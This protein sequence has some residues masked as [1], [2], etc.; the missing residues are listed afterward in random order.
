MHAVL[1][2]TLRL[3][4]PVPQNIRE[5]RS[6]PVLFPQSD[7][8]FPT[9]AEDTPVYVPASTPILYV[10]MLTQRNPVHWGPDADVFDPERWLDERLSCYLENPMIFTPFGAGP[11]IVRAS[12][13]VFV[14]RY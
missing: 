11:R 5:S 8:T 4:P 3:F 9:S 6:E 13:V 12:V 1:N 10:P 14:C 2:E 7:A